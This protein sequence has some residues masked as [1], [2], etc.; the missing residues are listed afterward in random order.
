[1]EEP[2]LTMGSGQSRLYSLGHFDHMFQLV[3]MITVDDQNLWGRGMGRREKQKNKDKQREENKL[4]CPVSD[5]VH[6]VPQVMSRHG[7][8]TVNQNIYFYA[9]TETS[10]LQPSGEEKM[11]RLFIATT[12]WKKQYL[13]FCL[14]GKKKTFFVPSFFLFCKRSNYSHI[15]RLLSSFVSCLP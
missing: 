10:S 12:A 7:T 6:G 2:Q 5:V 4:Q 9:H 15:F 8:G 14:G 13:L 1:V 3:F 11:F